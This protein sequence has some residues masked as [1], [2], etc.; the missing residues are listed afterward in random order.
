MSGSCDLSATPHTS[1]EDSDA[2]SGSC[3]PIRELEGSYHAEYPSEGESTM[4]DCSSVDEYVTEL[5]V[6]DETT[7]EASLSSPANCTDFDEMMFINSDTDLGL[8][9]WSAAAKERF[10]LE[11]GEMESPVQGGFV[12]ANL[13]A[14]NRPAPPVVVLQEVSATACAPMELDIYATTD[15]FLAVEEDVPDRAAVFDEDQAATPILMLNDGLVM[16][17]LVPRAPLSDSA[18]RPATPL[19]VSSSLNGAA[20]AARAQN[21]AGWSYVDDASSCVAR[22]NESPLP[23]PAL[24]HMTISGLQAAAKCTPTS[25]TLRRLMREASS[26]AYRSRRSS[27][28]AAAQAV[29][30]PEAAQPQSGSAD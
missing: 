22:S 25:P 3:T 10:S 2:C 1:A 27:A 30:V 11:Q 13:T 29:A 24:T 19:N 12:N 20:A 8:C 18:P 7:S 26:V 23:A 21:S 28:A 15:A 16:H 9:Q 4:H 6:V 5:H 14:V 17:A